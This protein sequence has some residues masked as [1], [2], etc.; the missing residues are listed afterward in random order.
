MKM[1][2]KN[3]LSKTL[4]AA[5]GATLITQAAHA[6][7]TVTY[8]PEDLLLGVQTITGTTQGANDLLVDIGQA[9]IYYQATSPFFVGTQARTGTGFTQ[10]HGN[11]VI[12]SPH[13]HW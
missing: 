2:M 3:L 8:T 7:T 1:Q 9:S 6:Q 12:G 10:N 4:L 5:A 13:H 11:T